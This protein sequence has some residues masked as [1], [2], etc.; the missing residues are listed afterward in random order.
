MRAGIRTKFLVFWAVV[1]AAAFGAYGAYVYWE[2]VSRARASAVAS[3]ALLSQEIEASRQFYTSVVAAR[4]M[5]A[6]VL[7]ISGAYHNNAM[8]IP[9]PADFTR[10]VSD[11]LGRDGGIRTEVISDN[12][13]NPAN[14]A[15]AGP[16]K[17]AL[18]H[19][20]KSSSSS[21]HAFEGSGKAETLRYMIPD[22]AASQ[23]CVDCH[24]RAPG[25]PKRDYKIG[26]VMGAVVTTVPVGAEIGAA[27][28]DAWRHIGYGFMV[29]A[30]IFA[31]MAVFARRVI[32]YPSARLRDAANSISG[33]GLS[34]FHADAADAAGGDEFS[35]A[36]IAVK[37][38]IDGVARLVEEI[39][40]NSRDSAAALDGARPLAR[41]ISDGAQRQSAALDGASA[42]MRGI[43]ASFDSISAC[44]YA[45]A[46]AARRAVDTSA[47]QGASLKNVLDGVDAV[48][49]DADEIFG[50]CRD[51]AASLKGIASAAEGVIKP[52]EDLGKT[53]NAACAG[54]KEAEM[55]AWSGVRFSEDVIKDARAGMQAAEG[56][57]A[58]VT[59]V[60][61][62]TL[63]AALMVNGLSDRIKEIGKIIDVLRDVAEE[64]NVLALNSAIAAARSGADGKKGAAAA[65]GIKDLTERAFASAKE[66][67]DAVSG[68]NAECSRVS[69]AMMRSAGSVAKAAELSREA[70]D[71][72]RRIVAAAQRIGAVGRELARITGEEARRSNAAAAEADKAVGALLRVFRAAEAQVKA[73][74]L[75]FR[76]ADRLSGALD[77]MAAY[78]KAADAA[79]GELIIETGEYGR[80]AAQISAIL[81]E[82]N[83]DTARALEALET[84]NRLSAEALSRAVELDKGGHRLAELNAELVEAVKKYRTW[85]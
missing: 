62:L 2:G 75:I 82:H 39:R 45:A 31:A 80:M 83:R 32:I 38:A 66:A 47:G 19:F 68:V 18:E 72:S 33:G 37:E 53:V 42:S 71:G 57:S 81:R 7:G 24:N 50:L 43:D 84:A 35:Q 30:A 77:A 16:E 1:W 65:N 44:A 29:S 69:A 70:G 10:G 63:E 22:V 34:S 55:N 12:P 36:H 9:L 14:A 73:G 79:N 54:V 3:A 11:A 28:S 61:E 46:G 5:E 23:A 15:P 78:A 27:V 17:E 8:Q 59:G 76:A 26:D 21:W 4:A 58:A 60:K 56:V 49:S 48:S 67:A 64:T 13:I 51:N 6:G 40:R 74:E 25:S 85:G 20:R 41:E 52:L